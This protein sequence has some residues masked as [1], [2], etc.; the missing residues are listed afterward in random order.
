MS[1][2]CTH[3]GQAHTDSGWPKRCAACARSTWKNPTP[4]AVALVPVLS[5]GSTGLLV[6]R[7]GIEP[8][9]GA[10]AL[11][12]GYVDWEESWQ[13]ACARELREETH[14]DLDPACFSLFDAQSPA[15]GKTLLIFGLAKPVPEEDLPA[16][17]ATQETPERL[18]LFEPA[19]LAFPLHEAALTRF[20]AAGA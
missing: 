16:F 10:L 17:T 11:P 20:F 19:P 9:R 1:A 15:G 13:V 2:F 8:Q 5:A 7:R 18:V 14:L 4:V 12:G 6:I 3:C